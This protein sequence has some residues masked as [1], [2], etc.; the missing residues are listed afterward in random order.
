MRTDGLVTLQLREDQSLLASG[1]GALDH[2]VGTS[3][4]MVRSHVLRQGS[5]PLAT[6]PERRDGTAG[7]GQTLGLGHGRHVA[8]LHLLGVDHIHEG[9]NEDLR[10][11]HG[12]AAL[13]AVGTDVLVR[14][15]LRLPQAIA[16]IDMSPGSAGRGGGLEHSE[17]DITEQAGVQRLLSNE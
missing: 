10:C 15:R 6:S 8:A 12:S 5:S 16:A 9:A 1:K 3:L 7:L 2:S 4:S 13:G 17:T 11:Q 14:R